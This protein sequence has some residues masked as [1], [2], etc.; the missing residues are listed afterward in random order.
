MFT[1]EFILGNLREEDLGSIWKKN[2]LKALELPERYESSN[3][4]N[5]KH[6]TDC[7]SSASKGLCWKEVIY[8]YGAENWHY[9][10]PRCPY[11]PLEMNEFYVS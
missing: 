6:F 10:D 4:R 9:P 11:A 8:A 5:C 3:C 2:R 7:R 1:P